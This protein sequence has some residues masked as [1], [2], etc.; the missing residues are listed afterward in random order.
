MNHKKLVNFASAIVIVFAGL[1]GGLAVSQDLSLEE[2]Q[3]ISLIKQALTPA[4]IRVILDYIKA[5]KDEA[6]DMLQKGKIEHDKELAFMKALNITPAQE[7][8]LIEIAAARIDQIK[9]LT[10]SWYASG[11]ALERAILAQ[12]P[13]PASIRSAAL[14]LGQDIGAAALVAVGMVKD[15]RQ[16]LTPGQAVLIENKIKEAEAEGRAEMDK[17]PAKADEALALIKA[18]DITPD[19]ITGAIKLAKASEPFFKQQGKIHEARM[20]ME[21]R[22]VLTADQIKVLK[23][24]KASQE[25]LFEPKAKEYEKVGIKTWEDFKLSK[26]QLDAL[27]ALVESNKSPILVLARSIIDSSL[28]LVNEVVAVSDDAKI[29]AA[30]D[31]IGEGIV[32]AAL[33]CSDMAQDARKILSAGQVDTVLKLVAYAEKEIYDWLQIM[34][35]QARAALKLRAD[36]NITPDQR[37][38]LEALAEKQYQ[39]E[40]RR[41]ERMLEMDPGDLLK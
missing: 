12:Q 32:Q 20:E 7:D 14:D 24:Y 35:D 3:G 19:Q 18:V 41:A 13:N 39:K 9:P 38:G 1:I 15:A 36:V 4:Q 16:V 28:A 37:K 30:A 17:A 5:H 21:L 27:V 34:P 6:R 10:D 26:A 22:Q 2:K 23:D 31:G 8:K 40:I 11:V 25:K 33:L 29:L